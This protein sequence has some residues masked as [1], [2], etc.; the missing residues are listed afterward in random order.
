MVWVFCFV[1]CL[2]FLNSKKLNCLEDN[3]ARPILKGFATLIQPCIYYINK[4]KPKYAVTQN[5]T[6]NPNFPL[7]PLCFWSLKELQEA[8]LC[9]TA[10]FLTTVVK[11]RQALKAPQREQVLRCGILRSIW[12]RKQRF[13]FC[14]ASSES[15]D[16]ASPRLL[17]SIKTTAKFGHTIYIV[18]LLKWTEEYFTWR[19]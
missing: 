8:K 13:V 5:I 4:L 19:I 18:Q 10:A 9:K 15:E 11:I 17:L 1:V 7:Q 2:V 3:Q 12:P 14:Y 6:P 16:I